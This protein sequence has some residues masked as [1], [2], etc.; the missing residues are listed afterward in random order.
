MLVPAPVQGLGSALRRFVDA[1][2]ASPALVA[3]QAGWSR[4]IRLVA[5]DTRATL[6]LRID[7]GHVTDLASDEEAD[8][9][10]TSDEATLC[11]IL[12]LRRGPNEPYVFG[13]LT[14][15]GP[16]ADFFRLDYITT[17]LCPA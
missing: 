10:I 6:A 14:V 5:S 8:V 3:E 15:R 17:R 13:E 1:Y 16:E 4:T 12:E 2:H 7:D 11:D 9:V